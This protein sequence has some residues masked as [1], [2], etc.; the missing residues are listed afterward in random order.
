M[1]FGPSSASAFAYTNE[2][3]PCFDLLPTYCLPDILIQ[4]SLLWALTDPTV[5]WKPVPM[6]P[7]LQVSAGHILRLVAVLNGSKGKCFSTK[8][9]GTSISNSVTAAKYPFF[10]MLLGIW[11]IDFCGPS[12]NMCSLDSG[13]LPGGWLC[14]E[15]CRPLSFGDLVPTNT[16]SH[17]SF[18]PSFIQMTVKLPEVKE[19]DLGVLH[20]DGVWDLKKVWF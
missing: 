2:L 17:P 14:L 19:D 13:C 12:A 1:H 4:L 3:L 5:T 8:V 20:I 10:P 16:Q 15:V 18:F 7:L 11:P 6:A 9:E